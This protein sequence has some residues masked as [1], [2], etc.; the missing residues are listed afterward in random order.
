MS[1]R[2][3]VTQT[4]FE[5]NMLLSQLE[6]Q[7]RRIHLRSRPRCIGLVLGNTCNLD[8]PHCYQAKNGD[9]LLKP[10]EIGRELRRELAGFYPYLSTLRLQGGE[11]FAYAGFG[12]L[13]DDVASST[14]RP[15]LSIS[16]NGTL[17]DEGWAERVVRAPFSNVTI[18]MDGATPATFA[19][20]RRGGQLEQVLGAVRRIRKWKDKL[21]SPFPRLDSFFVVM[22]SNFRE[23]PRFFDM[24]HE[25]G[26]EEA[27]LQTMQVNP[28]NTRR[29]PT[30]EFDE[31]IT[32]ES[33]I[34][35]LHSIMAETLPR[36]RKRFHSIRVSGLTSLFERFQ[37]D[38][39]FLSEE[40]DG[41]YP[42]NEGLN[43]PGAPDP[44]PNPWTTMF[45][46]ENGDVSLC[47]LSEPV[48]NVYE[49]PLAAIWNN[50]KALAKR[51]SMLAGRY[52]ASGCSEQWCGWREGEQCRHESPESTR[53]M[54]VQI[55]QLAAHGLAQGVDE[56]PVE[57]RLGAVRRQLQA[58]ESR[59]LELEA[60]FA[61]LCNRHAGMH[62]EGQRYID[63]LEARLAET[64][65]HTAHLEE[66]AQKA[67][68]DFRALQKFTNRPLRE[69]LV[70]RLK[71][72]EM[73]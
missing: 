4:T 12:D 10:A 35:E 37:L 31:S 6:Y 71:S 57:P 56:V 21:G 36:E 46:T 23:I 54:L 5:T 51:S 53:E 64:G 58:R 41:L 67:V 61:Q 73:F 1:I 45:V 50:P 39:S 24:L 33:E 68:D 69:R 22:R 20:L 7:Q 70:S 42:D 32:A 8:C 48:G 13:L 40:S 15:I 38:S 34:R 72:L 11:A 30:L 16:T 28:E 47:F 60:L 27:A 2:V 49:E 26:F 17:I 63:H 62:E 9:N 66:K 59:I 43:Q 19:R 14:D 44:C 55:R 52:L 18:S 29:E 25:N 3:I 65:L